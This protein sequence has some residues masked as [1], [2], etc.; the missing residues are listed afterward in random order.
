VASPAF[1]ELRFIRFGPF[2]LDVRAGEL[3]KHGT[4]IKLREQPVRIL[5]MLLENAGEVV[6]RDEIRQQLWPNNTVVEFDHGIN[7]AI[8]KLRDALLDSAAEPRYVETVARR[9]YRFIAQVEKI[10]VPQAAPE[11]TPP[12]TGSHYRLLEKLD[13]GGMGVVYRAEDLKLG[14]MV[15]IKCLPCPVGELPESALRRF[16]REARAAAVLN[17]PHICTVHGFEQIDGQP[18]IVMELVEGETL[19]HRLACGPLPQA[20]ALSLSIQI[21]DALAEAHRKGI[22]HRDLK[23]GNIML[24]K[25]GAK[26]LDFGLAKME[27]C[28]VAGSLTG[29]TF[30]PGALAG[31]LGHM[32]PEQ[33][34]GKETDARADI[35]SFGVVMYQMFSGK[36]PFEGDSVAGM[37]AAVLEREPAPFL[38]VAF[39]RL[40][41]RCLAK[42]PDDRWQ[43]A[44]DLKTNLEWLAEGESKPLGTGTAR[45][46]EPWAWAAVA[47]IG[48]F[49][50]F[51][52]VW[53]R[54]V[55]EQ[56]QSV[57]MTI[58]PPPGIPLARA[59]SQASV[60]EISPD[61][62]SVMFL[63]GGRVYVR[64][65]DSLEIREVPGSIGSNPPF[66]SPDSSTVAVPSIASFQLMRVRLPDG[67]PQYI[68][69]MGI[70][71]GADWSEAGRI[72]IATIQ[73]GF[74]M[75]PAS[76]GE[77]KQ[78]ETPDF[79]KG[80]LSTYPAFLPGREDFLFLFAPAE[81]RDNPAIYLATLRDRK[82]V[83]P[84]MLVRNQTPA[85]Y[86][87][88]GG[89][90]ILFVRSNNLYSQKLDRVGRK[91]MGDAELVVSGVSS[92]P[93]LRADFS[94]DRRGTIAW[95]PGTAAVSQIVAFDRSGNLLGTSGPAE[96]YA[97]VTLS[98]DEKQ[99]L[100]RDY[101]W[102]VDIGHPGRQELPRG[103]DWVGWAADR[104]KLIGIR[105]P[106]VNRLFVEMPSGGSGELHTLADGPR[107]PVFSGEATISP[108]GKQVV[109]AT[110]REILCYQINGTRDEKKPRVLET[111]GAMAPRFSPDGRWIVYANRPS[112]TG[113][114]VE[115]FPKSSPRRQIA[116]AGGHPVWRADGKEI[117]YDVGETLM[118][119]PVE[120]TGPNQTFGAPRKLF[121]GLRP[122][123]AAVGGQSPLAVSRDGSH[124]FWIQGVE[125]P[126]SNMIHVKTNAFK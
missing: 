106:S 51:G 47:A 55:K 125:Q 110:D 86:T 24:T 109:G 72:L 97:S 53:L 48:A 105:N 83:D 116:Q 52:S 90:R 1:A 77:L 98:P 58:V 7:A 4:K 20:K 67:A 71:R 56:P 101:A 57:M 50:I 31:T 70:A 92:Q 63:A 61:G 25:S 29:S 42:N 108:D 99:L 9:G 16:E 123:P 80:G 114:Y 103:V 44:S 91:L 6:L 78:V 68:S 59:G 10:G 100:L 82:I 11:L 102:L 36:R 75:A 14:R 35:F 94:V 8:Q 34:Q 126:N 15:A 19:E 112:G 23:P 96:L 40:V 12:E 66:W 115:S 95:R 124:I 37:V 117:L 113:L 38:P 107:L 18:A 46:R 89:G 87:P 64:H 119:I 62:S 111:N 88:A 2:E 74:L 45:L 118:S 28:P 32:S 27:S 22:V 21:A 69:P 120:G 3:R 13:E 49:T 81:N 121:S 65:L 73:D 26:V 17:H 93:L 84:V 33:A 30:E 54:T 5:V 79:L 104:S 85:R 76:G 39:D 60:P 122:S 43:S 41:R